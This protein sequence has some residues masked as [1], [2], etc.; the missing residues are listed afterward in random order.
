MIVLVGVLP[1]LLVVAGFWSVLVGVKSE[2]VSGLF[3]VGFVSVLAHFFGVFV[4]CKRFHGVRHA[5]K[6]VRFPIIGH[7]RGSLLQRA[8]AAAFAFALAF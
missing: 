6:C 1:C 7:Y 8:S 2:H 4:F 3:L 5:D